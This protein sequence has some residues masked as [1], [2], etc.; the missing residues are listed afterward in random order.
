MRYRQPT[1][2]QFQCRRE[3]APIEWQM[4]GKFG[5]QHKGNHRLGD[6]TGG[7]GFQNSFRSIR[8]G[9]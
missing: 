3:F 1:K 6:A 8:F 7:V 4:P 5:D 9:S 2:C